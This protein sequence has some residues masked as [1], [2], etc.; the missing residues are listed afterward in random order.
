MLKEVNR[1]SYYQAYYN[2]NYNR[3]HSLTDIQKIEA[4]YKYYKATDIEDLVDDSKANERVK[5]I[6]NAQRDYYSKYGYGGFYFDD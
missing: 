2:T 6:M 5:T 1:N 3:W 4:A